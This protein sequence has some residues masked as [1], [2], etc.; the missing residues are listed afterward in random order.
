VR[1]VNNEAAKRIVDSLK[2]I[3]SGESSST[4]KKGGEHFVADDGEGLG[5]KICKIF[6]ARYKEDSELALINAIT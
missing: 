4:A 3:L 2:S 1:G 6:L 5:E